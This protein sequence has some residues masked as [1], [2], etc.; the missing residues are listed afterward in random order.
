MRRKGEKR[1]RK[2]REEKKK[3]NPEEDKDGEGEG[4]LVET[5]ETRGAKWP[6]VHL[7]I[8]ELVG[9]RQGDEGM[10]SQPAN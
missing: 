1:G 3:S 5:G 7:P 10:D 8:R 9:G 2:F 4:T 6:R